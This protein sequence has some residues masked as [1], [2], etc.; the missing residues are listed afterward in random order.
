VGYVDRLLGKDETC[1]HS[2]RPHGVCLL[3]PAAVFIAT[4]FA[5]TFLLTELGT[6]HPLSGAVEGVARFLVVAGA[7]AAT[8]FLVVLPF[9]RWATTNYVITDRRLLTRWGLITKEAR[10]LPLSRL[11]DVRYA[12]GPLQRMLGV[13]TMYVEA[14]GEAGP[15]VLASVPDVEVVQR[16]LFRLHERR[17]AAASAL[18]P[19]SVVDLRQDQPGG[20]AAGSGASAPSIGHTPSRGGNHS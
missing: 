14:M 16:E 15:L 2:F 5:A 8:W 9:V 20:P 18:S 4:A 19:R 6:R 7:V 12:A 17:L 10:D 1:L 3:R 13:G 11:T